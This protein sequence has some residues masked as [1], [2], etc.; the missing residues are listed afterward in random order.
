MLELGVVSSPTVNFQPLF[1]AVPQWAILERQIS[2]RLSASNHGDYP[3]WQAALARLPDVNVETV[4]FADTVTI[5]GKVSTEQEQQ[6]RSALMAL[7]PWRKGPFELFGIK[8]DSEWR[9][10]WKWRRAAPHL[11]N[12]HNALVLDV[13][14]ANGYFGWRLLE[15]GA[16]LIAGVEPTLVYFMQHQAIN[17]YVGG[18]QNWLVPLTFE[19]L[20]RSEFDVV[21]SMG[22]I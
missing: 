6:L 18:K 7:H 11:K 16:R 17:R 20:P 1:E 14:C 5:K 2:E 22:V 9:S 10:D 15:A 3:I 19:A 8:I 4:G 12:L 21:L 13:G